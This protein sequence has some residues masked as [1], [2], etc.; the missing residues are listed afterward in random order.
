[1]ILLVILSVSFLQNLTDIGIYPFVNLFSHVSTIG[2]KSIAS[3]MVL[4][5]LSNKNKLFFIV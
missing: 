2:F 1:L 4:F 5:A 3:V